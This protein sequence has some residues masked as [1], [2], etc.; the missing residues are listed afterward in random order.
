[1][2]HTLDLIVIALAVWRVSR[3]IVREDGPFDVFAKLRGAIDPSQ[4]TWIG[5]GLNCIACV[6]FWLALVAALL[7]GLSAAE[8]LAISAAAILINGGLRA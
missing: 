3:I 4:K 2:F 6:S 8:W 5:R 7:Y 1:M